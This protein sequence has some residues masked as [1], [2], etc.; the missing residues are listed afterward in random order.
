MHTSHATLLT[1]Y[2]EH[3]QVGVKDQCHLYKS[4]YLYKM[5][6]TSRWVKIGYPP[7]VLDSR[8][9]PGSAIL[10]NRFGRIPGAVHANQTGGDEVREF[11]FHSSCSTRDMRLDSRRYTLHSMCKGLGILTGRSMRVLELISSPPK[12]WLQVP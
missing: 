9:N 7:T 4:T 2:Q 12:P 10:G 8:I 11:K 1:N 5:M 6:N 3:L